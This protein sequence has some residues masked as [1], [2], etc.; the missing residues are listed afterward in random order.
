M[1]ETVSLLMLLFASVAGRMLLSWLPAGEPGG[2]APRELPVTWAV[3]FALGSAAVLYELLFQH[4]Y[5]LYQN[6]EGDPEFEVFLVWI[7]LGAVRIATLPAGLVPRHPL[8]PARSGAFER[9]LLAL[10]LAIALLATSLRVEFAAGIVI[11]FTF[12][13]AT[14]LLVEHGLTVA[15]REI[16]FRRALLV[17]LA[18]AIWWLVPRPD[19]RTTS[20]AL[21]CTLVGV[22][23][24]AW[25]RRADAR[26][27]WL[28]AAGL[29]TLAFVD[30]VR[31]PIGA[32]GAV[33]LV[34]ATAGPSRLMAAGCCMIT[35]VLTA[36]AM[37][38][39]WPELEIAVA[40]PWLAPALLAACGI[41]MLC[42]VPA[43]SRDES[44]I[45]PPRREIVFL[46]SLLALGG[47]ALALLPERS[48]SGHF[49]WAQTIEWTSFLPC[50]FLLLGLRI[51][52]AEPVPGRD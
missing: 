4:S 45:D 7:A 13:A 3:S 48:R 8:S 19:W 20:A 38:F 27:L 5:R 50:A 28:S 41:A 33:A 44:S 31:W 43:A 29:S 26:G 12:L 34:A 42:F 14:I 49:D 6:T 1:M 16:R 52:P 25:L 17:G 11:C 10:A 15:R 22:G 47:S 24:I 21:F 18:I 36:V 35:G 40:R 37:R 30:P 46:G 39:H 2:H 9:F 32:A 23:A 51:L